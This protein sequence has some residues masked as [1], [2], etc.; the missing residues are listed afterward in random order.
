MH[1]IQLVLL[2]HHITVLYLS[3]N[4]LHLTNT[5]EE[6]KIHKSANILC[7]IVSDKIAENQ[8]DLI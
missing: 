6:C 8:R 3:T 7:S 4:T 5:V 1:V 2:R